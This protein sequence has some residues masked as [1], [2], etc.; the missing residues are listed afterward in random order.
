MDHTDEAIFEFAYRMALDDA[1]GQRAYISRGE[2]SKTKLR[3]LNEPKQVVKKYIE[4]IFNSDS[5]P[6]FEETIAEVEK[7]FKQYLNGEDDGEFTFGNA[8][9]LVNMTAKYMFIATFERPELRRRFEK[10]H[11]PMDSIV[12]GEVIKQ[13][14]GNM[15][16]EG[17]LVEKLQRK[18]ECRDKKL[19]KW[20]VYLKQPWSS[21]TED[22]REQYDLFQELVRYLC[23]V[24][25]SKLSPIEFDFRTW[26]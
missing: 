6:E 25:D 12:V 19:S 15:P 10:C 24:D 2:G 3:K 21:M 18:Y 7:T 9:K 4:A 23:G 13:M 26:Q 5:Q 11:C 14:K 8:Q 22:D 16:A 17:P 20:T 1:I